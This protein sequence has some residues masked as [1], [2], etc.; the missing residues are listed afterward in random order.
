LARPKVAAQRLA[1]ERKQW[2]E[3]HHIP[4]SLLR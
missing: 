2:E 3:E 1:A 4:A